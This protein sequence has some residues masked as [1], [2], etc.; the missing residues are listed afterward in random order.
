VT[1]ITGSWS[2]TVFFTTASFGTLATSASDVQIDRFR[3]C[4]YRA[5]GPHSAINQPL[6]NQNYVV[7]RAGDGTT[8]F[9]CPNSGSGPTW[10]HQP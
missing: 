5:T 7:I 8:A 3:H 4:R 2:G 9:T 10:A 1:S 6:L